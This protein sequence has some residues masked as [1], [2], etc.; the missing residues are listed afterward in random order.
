MTKKPNDLPRISVVIPSYNKAAYIRNTLQSIVDQAYPSIEIIIQDG[1]STDGSVEIIKDFAKKYPKLFKWES[2]KD[3]G[4]LDAINKG[5]K[6]AKG[7]ILTYINADDIYEKGALLKIGEEFLKQTNTLWITGYGDIIDKDGNKFG[8]FVTRYKNFLLNIN[9]YRVLLIVN[10]ITQA[11]TFLNRKAFEKYGPFTGTRNYIMEYD[12]WLKLGKIQMPLVI[13]E[14]LSSFRLASGNISTTAA[15]ELLKID[16]QI[17]EKYT[18][19]KLSLV[20]HKLHNLG[21]IFLLNF[22]R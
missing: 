19:N 21:R 20:L 16:N 2:K 13:K 3:K 6:K 17:V 4:Q 5:L 8:G 18:Q 10:F 14:N 1:K 11:S 9:S 22:L 12:F 15:K 7:E